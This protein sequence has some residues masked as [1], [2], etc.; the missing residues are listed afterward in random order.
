MANFIILDSHQT[1]FNYS[2][3]FD[4][5]FP[6]LAFTVFSAL[7]LSIVGSLITR[8]RIPFYI[9]SLIFIVFV[10][11]S[12]LVY[13]LLTDHS[14]IQSNSFLIYSV[15]GLAI[16]LPLSFLIKNVPINFLKRISYIG[17]FSYALYVIHCPIV[18][19][20]NSL[21]LTNSLLIRPLFLPLI[22]FVFPLLFSILISWFLE[23]R[24]Q[25]IISK[26]LKKYFKI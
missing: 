24:L 15:L 21:S 11:V 22:I 1:T 13:G 20:F 2:I 10:R 25:P 23:C 7:A 3:A 14:H 5:H 17:S 6:A 18:F 8:T 26:K 12:L 4:F 9:A 16:L 19:W